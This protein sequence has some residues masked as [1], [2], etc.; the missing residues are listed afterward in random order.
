MLGLHRLPGIGPPSVPA[1]L[2][3]RVALST[4]GVEIVAQAFLLGLV[5]ANPGRD[6]RAWL[7][8]LGA[9]CLGTGLSAPTITY[10]AG[11]LAS[12]ARAGGFPTAVVLAHSVH[13]L[14]LAQI[15]VAGLYGDPKDL[16]NDAGGG[17]TS[18]R[19]AFPTS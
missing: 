16:V 3:L 10:M 13:P 1:A 15:V 17:R 9:V 19:G 12:S 14:T 2:R 7:R 6:P 5:V 18:S 11:L 8:V 4:T